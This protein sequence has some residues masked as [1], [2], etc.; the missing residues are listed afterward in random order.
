MPRDVR[1]IT[2]HGPD[3]TIEELQDCEMMLRSSLNVVCEAMQKGMSVEVMKRT[4]LLEEWK[5]YETGF[6][7]CDEWISMIYQ[8]LLHRSN[9]ISIKSARDSTSSWC[10]SAMMVAVICALRSGLV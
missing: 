7:S 3:Y 4:R 2:G 10:G 5:D 9:L 6:F 1:I 8:S